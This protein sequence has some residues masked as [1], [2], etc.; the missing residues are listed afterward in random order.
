MDLCYRYNAEDNIILFLK[1]I[2]GRS[3]FTEYVVDKSIADLERDI[4]N[5]YYYINEYGINSLGCE[6]SQEAITA[7]KEY[8]IGKVHEGLQLA[9]DKIIEI[10]L[11]INSES[12]QLKDQLKQA[13]IDRN[14]SLIKGIKLKQQDLS[15][16]EHIFRKLADTIAWGYIVRDH[17]EARRL[18]IGRETDSIQNS[19]IEN[20]SEFAKRFAGKSGFN[21]C[22]LTDITSFIQLGDAICSEPDVKNETQH[23]SL[24]EIKSGKINRKLLN[25]IENNNFDAHET[26][27]YLTKKELEQGLRIM[28]QYRRMSRSLSVIKDGK[29]IDAAGSNINVIDATHINVDYYTN[30][31]NNLFDTCKEVGWSIEVIDECL[32]LGLYDINIPIKRAYY[33]F[34]E[35]MKEM[36]VRYPPTNFQSTFECPLCKPPFLIGIDKMN[37]A[38][39]ALG[40]KIALSCLDFDKWFEI[41]NEMGLS[42]K[43]LSRSES[44]EYIKQNRIA[45]LAKYNGKLIKTSHNGHSSMIGDA[46]PARIFFE[47]LRP[48]S[49]MKLLKESHIQMEKIISKSESNCG[50][51]PSSR[52]AGYYG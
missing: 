18:Y 49:A 39:I 1:C 6:V 47:F 13:N 30:V 52:A 15:N 41:G 28:E 7:K 51:A 21:F 23:W 25:I 9:Q 5:I 36:D 42:C 3:L 14:K 20:Y 17:T 44:N 12:N 16:R 35:W 4:L 2:D 37:L 38:D 46:V 34:T 50:G 31:V 24:V 11:N 27:S 43:W 45:D 8:F 32:Y 40:K 22:L 26:I 33:A 10:L 29:G 19:D 48:I